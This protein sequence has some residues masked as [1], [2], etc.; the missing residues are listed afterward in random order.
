MEAVANLVIPALDEAVRRGWAD[1]D[2]VAA[3]GHSYGGYAVLALLAGTNR[4]RAGIASA[5]VANLASFYGEGEF[6]GGQ[7]V[8]HWQEWAE[9]GQGEMGGPPWEHPERYVA[10]SPVFRLHQIRAPL[11]LLAGK[12]SSVDI[13]QAVE[14][15][16][17]LQ[18]LGRE[19]E[20]V[21]YE[22][23]R[24]L[25][26]EATPANARDVADRVLGWLARYLR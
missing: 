3:I 19:A 17:G 24:H 1:P 14:V 2:R 23:G 16:S 25:P 8:A 7:L 6:R 26:G 20:L 18:R 22:D 11:L 12:Q 5:P 10:N 15:F 4:F 13:R 21:L 9:S